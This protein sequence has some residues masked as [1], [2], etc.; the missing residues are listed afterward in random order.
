MK[1]IVSASGIY[2]TFFF[3]LKEER[4]DGERKNGINMFFS[5]DVLYVPTA[6]FMLLMLMISIEDDGNVLL[7]SIDNKG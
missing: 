5:Q 7:M 6:K 4:N 1:L 2:N 3:L